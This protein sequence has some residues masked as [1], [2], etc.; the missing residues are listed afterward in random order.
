MVGIIS[1]QRQG[2]MKRK[3]WYPKHPFQIS[4][5]PYHIVP[6]FIAPVLPGETMK[7][8]NFQSRVVTDPINNP[9]VGWWIEYYFFYVKLSDL[10]E[11]EELR[12]M[13]LNPAWSP[14]DVTTAQGGTTATDDMYYSGGTGMIDYNTLCYRRVVDEFFRDEDETYADHRFA[15]AA[16]G[17]IRTY[18]LAQLV[19]NSV[20]DSVSLRD[21]ETAQ[22]VTLI[23]AATSDVL[24]ASEVEAGMQLWRQ[25]RMYG[26]TELS[27]EDWLAAFGVRAEVEEV[28]KPELIRYLR[29][30]SYPTNTIDPTSGA[31]RSAVSW[32]VQERADK[33]RAF[34]EP[35]FLYGVSVCRPKV[36]LRAQEGTFTSLFNDY[37]AWMPPFGMADPSWTRKVVSTSAG[38][39]QTAV[40]DADGYVVDLK[41]LLLY[42]EQ[43][44][45]HGL[46]ETTRNFM[47][48][49]SADLTNVR[50]PI[51]LADITELFVTPAS[52]YYVRQDG[53]VDLTIACSPHNPM[54]DTSPRG[55]ERSGA[56][57][58]GF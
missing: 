34:R 22:D 32:T 17:V 6:F 28:H 3:Q 51:A 21:D 8:L 1:M 56:T 25:Q 44:T 11:R 42:G 46:S 58:G 23:D 52:A 29:E 40:T 27:Y 35:G 10:Y 18:S 55:G 33:N 7:N 48:A 16:A 24:T 15:D 43:Y 54:I 13:V 53:I 50:Y 9:L 47:D 5:I 41:D 26:I 57:S 31:A 45:N 30:W 2:T 38:P 49:V 12:E 37:K 36:Y 19:G 14:T 4:H 20:M 39:L